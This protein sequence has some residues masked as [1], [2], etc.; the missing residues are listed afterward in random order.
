MYAAGRKK[1]K[2]R[3]WK[4]GKEEEREEERDWGRKEIEERE[5]DK[6]GE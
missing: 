5:R 1:K 4:R 2:E 3:K 6:S